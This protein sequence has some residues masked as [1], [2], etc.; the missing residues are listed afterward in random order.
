ME[1]PEATT[2]FVPI[3][4][5]SLP[6]MLM[7]AP[8]LIA[9]SP[10]TTFVSSVSFEPFARVSWPRERVLLLAWISPPELTTIWVALPPSVLLAEVALKVVPLAVRRPPLATTIC[11]VT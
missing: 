7:V 5:K 1:S 4:L 8:L 2:P 3:L 11:D 6:L 10:A 9:S